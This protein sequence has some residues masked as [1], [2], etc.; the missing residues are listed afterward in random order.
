[1][2][3]AN[4]KPYQSNRVNNVADKSANANGPQQQPAYELNRHS[5]PDVHLE[6]VLLPTELE[7]PRLG[8]LPAVCWLDG[9]WVVKLCVPPGTRVTL[10]AT[11]LCRCLHCWLL[12]P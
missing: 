8:C 12:P 3:D 10:P 6:W 11:V 1:M 2:V 7:A 5:L 9:D 4:G